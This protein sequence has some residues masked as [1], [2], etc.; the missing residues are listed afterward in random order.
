MKNHFLSLFDSSHRWWTLSLFLGSVLLIIG[1][2]IE[3]TTD[4]LPGIAM[5]LGG[6]IALFFAFLHPWRETANYGILAGVSFGLIMVTFL[7]IQ[8]M[9][10]LKM[11]EYLSEA[12]VMI[13]I[14]LLCVP[15]I[16]AGLIGAII[17]A[18]RKK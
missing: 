14:G 13:F 5:L 3:G 15:G 4:N 17:C 8:I 2:Q 6:M 1:S 11:T 16:L 10:A 7:A 9:S 12:V 18:T